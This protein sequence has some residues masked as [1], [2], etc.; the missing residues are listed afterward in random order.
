MKTKP[1]LRQN[2]L[3]AARH[4]EQA[5][6]RLKLI[7]HPDRLRIICLLHQHDR[8]PV[9]E[10]CARLRLGQSTVSQHLNQMKRQGLLASDREKRQIFYR[11]AEPRLIDMLQ[12]LCSNARRDT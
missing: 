9:S 5:A 6:Q 2:P 12:C 4:I 11:I 10:L 1:C 8:L 7:A 3:L